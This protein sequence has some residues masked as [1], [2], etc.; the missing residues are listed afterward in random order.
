MPSRSLAC[1]RKGCDTARWLLRPGV[2]RQIPLI[3]SPAHS[4]D[5]STCTRGTDIVQ[6]RHHGCR[7]ESASQALIRHLLWSRA[8]AIIL[9]NAKGLASHMVGQSVHSCCR[10]QA[11]IVAMSMCPMTRHM[12]TQLYYIVPG[13]WQHDSKR[14]VNAHRQTRSAAIAAAQAAGA[15]RLGRGRSICPRLCC[16]GAGAWCPSEFWC[17]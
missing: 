17:A 3:E 15:A 14:L 13:S 10:L 4:F 5:L 1:V 11:C 8:N 6:G 16:T 12:S 9:W 7:P 2:L